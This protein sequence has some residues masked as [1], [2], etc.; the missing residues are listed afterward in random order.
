MRPATPAALLSV[1]LLVTAVAVGC[2][3]HKVAVEPTHHTIQVEPIY[4]TIDLNIKVQ[5]ELQDFFAPIEQGPSALDTAAS[6]GNPS[7]PPAS[8][9]TSPKAQP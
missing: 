1:L 8:A 7:T 2:T 6:T 4:L 3:Q 9:T 5:R